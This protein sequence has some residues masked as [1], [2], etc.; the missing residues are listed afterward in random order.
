MK[1]VILIISILL[2]TTLL[3]IG[4]AYGF[5]KVSQKQVVPPSAGALVEVD[6]T[7]VDWGQIQYNGGKVKA[8]YRI[9]NNGTETLKL[10]GAT[11]SCAC[12]IG[13]IT[14]NGQIS[15]PFGM[16]APLTTTIEV[17]PGKDAIVEALFDPAFHGPGGIGP[18]SRTITV[19]TNDPLNQT[20][21]FQA[22]G[23]V[24]K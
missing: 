1:S 16:H 6:K 13:T 2:I 4:V 9:T 17:S 15:P 21:N 8:T 23:V 11:T 22:S 19:Q 5:T 7:S 24:V 18:I 3:L 10:Y 20:L 12:T 14:T